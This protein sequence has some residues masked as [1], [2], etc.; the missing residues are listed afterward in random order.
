MTKH[1]PVTKRLRAWLEDGNTGTVPEILTALRG[2]SKCAV[3]A[4]LERLEETGHAARIDTRVIRYGASNGLVSSPVWGTPREE[5]AGPLVQRALMR[6]TALETA[7][8]GAR[9]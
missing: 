7:W 4:A 5:E 6:R 2:A 1:I 3:V 9:Q 8:A